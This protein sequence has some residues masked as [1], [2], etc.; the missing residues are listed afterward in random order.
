MYFLPESPSIDF[1]D[2]AYKSICDSTRSTNFHFLLY[3]TRKNL[4]NLMVST[5][6]CCAKTAT[7]ITLK[8]WSSTLTNSAYLCIRKR[9]VLFYPT[10]GNIS[11]SK[12]WWNCQNYKRHELCNW[13]KHIFHIKAAQKNM[14]ILIKTI[15][16]KEICT[17]ASFLFL[18]LVLKRVNLRMAWNK[19]ISW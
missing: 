3:I 16:N 13:E 10:L 15:K 8:G 14:R 2:V 1:R 7:Q 9:V 4:T 12:N 18:L 5:I 11:Q 19:H 17:K 6:A